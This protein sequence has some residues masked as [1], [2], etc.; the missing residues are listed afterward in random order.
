MENADRIGYVMSCAP[1][2]QEADQ[3]AENFINESILLYS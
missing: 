3:A 1:T 2:R